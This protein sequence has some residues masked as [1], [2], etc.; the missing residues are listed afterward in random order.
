MGTAS[1]TT[2]VEGV[3]R[4]GEVLAA[5]VD[6]E[7]DVELLRD[8]PEGEDDV[9][10]ETDADDDD[11]SVHR[12]HLE[13]LFDQAGTA[14]ALDD[15]G[16]RT[17][18]GF[19]DPTRE[20]ALVG[21]EGGTGP[22]TQGQVT[23]ERRRL[24]HDHGFD[25]HGQGPCHRGQ[26]DG[27]GAEH[28][29]AVGGNHPGAPDGAPHDGQRLDQRLFVGQDRRRE[30][31]ELVG[32]HGHELGETPRALQADEL[33]LCAVVGPT[34]R[35]VCADAAARE[36]PGHHRRALLPAIVPDA[37]AHPRHRAGDLVT[38]DPPGRRQLAGDVEVA[39]ADATARHPQQDF[40]GPRIRGGDV[41]ELEPRSILGEN[42]SSHPVSP[43]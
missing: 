33:E 26:P 42:R 10:L 6:R 37:R 14:A 18:H 3:E 15:H 20:R 12:R 27:P 30:R 40:A 8:A 28:G 7:A 25:P 19:E 21:I 5:V 13:G 23:T 41:D 36:G 17:S 31:E 32:A 38:E 43:R 2:T 9:V 29:H 24:A 11:P 1:S 16:G 4:V 34:T 22:E 39:A 35:A